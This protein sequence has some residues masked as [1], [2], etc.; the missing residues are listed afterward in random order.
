MAFSFSLFLN[1]SIC[2]NS[3]RCFV[4][5]HSDRDRDGDR[6]GDRDEDR[7]R[8]RDRLRRRDSAEGGGRATMDGQGG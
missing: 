4:L 7:D 5:T 2:L 3:T 6:D 8:D 1:R